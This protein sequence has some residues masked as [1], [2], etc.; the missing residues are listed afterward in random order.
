MKTWQCAAEIDELL[1]HDDAEDSLLDRSAPGLGA[2]LDQ[3]ITEQP[4]TSDRPLQAAG[5]DRRGRH[6]GRLRGRAER[7][8]QAARWL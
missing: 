4:G 6:G 8:G 3:P 5:T 1:K 7:A 2:T